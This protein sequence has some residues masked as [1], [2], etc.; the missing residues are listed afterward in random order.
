VN[1][2]FLDVAED[3]FVDSYCYYE[4][5]HPGLGERFKGEILAAISWIQENPEVLHLRKGFYRRFN[6]KVFPYG[7][8]YCIHQKTLWVLAIQH[9]SRKPNQW[10]S[11]RER[12]L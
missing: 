10:L 9:H 6:L 2:K 11:R 5:I 12:I 7:I 8:C 4:E 1:L 3:E